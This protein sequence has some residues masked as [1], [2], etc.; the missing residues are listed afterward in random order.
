MQGIDVN[1][2]T[3]DSG[4]LATF[5]QE[6]IARSGKFKKHT[7]YGHISEILEIGYCSF[8][9]YILDVKWYQVMTG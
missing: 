7:Y 2:T 1:C 8:E 3:Y 9:L 4:V 6:T 5:D